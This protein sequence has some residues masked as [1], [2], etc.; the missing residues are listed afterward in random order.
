MR[1]FKTVLFYLFIICLC[2]IAVYIIK[3]IN[4]ETCTLD[5]EAR[6]NS[7]GLYVELTGGWTHYKYDSNQNRELIVL[8]HGG[9]VAGIHV[10]EKTID[11]L[12]SEGYDVLAYDLFGRG[13]SDRPNVP[14]NPELLLQQFEELLDSLRIERRIHIISLSLGAM[15]AVDYTNAH[16]NKVRSIVFIDPILQGNYHPNPL[17]NV[18]VLS[19]FIMTVYWY[20]RAVENQRKEFINMNLFNEYATY[21]NYFMNFK[22]YKHVNYSTWMYTLQENYLP[23]LKSLGKQKV[24]ILLLYGQNDPYFL[25]GSVDK[26]LK[27]APLLEVQEVANSGHMPHYEKPE[28]VNS[29]IL[30]FLKE[31]N[32]RK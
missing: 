22:G 8:I 14:Y 3:Y 23:K 24:P 2:C 4:Q 15:I 17:L 31:N 16:P 18:P 21:L 29:R 26:Y 28:E 7:D 5:K 1:Y 19:D 12:Y 27:I 20:P 13:Y 32:C 9:G 25:S 30:V 6:I 11:K 10:W